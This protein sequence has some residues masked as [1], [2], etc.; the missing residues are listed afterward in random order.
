MSIAKRAV[1]TLQEALET[2][3]RLT[4]LCDK[5]QEMIRWLQANIQEFKRD[6]DEANEVVMKLLDKKLDERQNLRDMKCINDW[7]M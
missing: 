6:R 2:N 5:Q 7:I 4:A 3:A 1:S